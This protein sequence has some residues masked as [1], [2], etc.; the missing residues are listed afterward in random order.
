MYQKRKF[1]SSSE[2]KSTI[3]ERN[4]GKYAFSTICLN[5]KTSQFARNQFN[6]SQYNGTQ[7]TKQ[8]ITQ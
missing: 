1:N 2:N 3:L 5:Y 8:P 6:K 4:Y 7:F